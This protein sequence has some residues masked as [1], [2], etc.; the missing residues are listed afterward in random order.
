MIGTIIGVMSKK[1]LGKK[2]LF[3]EEGKESV[4]LHFDELNTLLIVFKV[5]ALPPQAFHLIQV[6]LLLHDLL[7]K[8]VLSLLIAVVD[9][10][11]LEAVVVKVLKPADVQNT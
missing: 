3:L 10:E 6:L 9:E 11:L 8:K 7:D 4:V 2:G 5:N 1:D